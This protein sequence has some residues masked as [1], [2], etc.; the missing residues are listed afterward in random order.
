[1]N[2]KDQCIAIQLRRGTEDQGPKMPTKFEEDSVKEDEGM[3]AETRFAS[4][5]TQSVT[6]DGTVVPILDVD[7][8]LHMVNDP[9]TVMEELQ[10]AMKEIDLCE[11]ETN[12]RFTEQEARAAREDDVDTCVDD[13]VSIIHYPSKFHKQTSS[14]FYFELDFT[15]L[16]MLMF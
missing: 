2:P 13:E 3:N 15:K 10:R 8:I 9:N 14:L 11:E 1:M 6:V 12:Y 16:N 4:R 5:I 7:A